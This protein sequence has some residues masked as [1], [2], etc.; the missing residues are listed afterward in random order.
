[1]T[2]PES[3][4]WPDWRRPQ[5]IALGVGAAGTLLCLLGVFLDPQQF[6]FAYLIAFLYWTGIALGGLVIWMLHNLTGGAWGALIR[7]ILEAGSRTLPLLALFFVPVALGMP[8]VYLWVNPQQAT[9]HQAELFEQKLIPGDAL[10]EFQHVL[11]EKRVL[12]EREKHLL[13]HKA[14]FLNLPFFLV[15]TAIYF[16]VWIVLAFF[17]N[18]LS[19]SQD[20]QASED[21]DRKMRGISGPGLAIYALTMTLAAID[22]IMSLEPLWWSTIFG[23]LVATGQLL[24]ALA[25][26]V[27]IAAWLSRRGP[28][29]ELASPT[30]WN[31]LGSLLLAFV[32]LWSYMMFSQLLLIYS[33]ALVEEIPW[34]TIRSAGGWQWLGLGLALFYFLLPFLVLLSRD[35]KREPRRLAVV[36]ALILFMSFV[37][38]VWMVGPV[39]SPGRFY[40]SWMTIAALAATGGFWLSFLGWQLRSRPLVPV[41]DSSVPDALHLREELRHV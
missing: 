16:V 20:R 3:Q 24:P 26:A 37:H 28:L 23:A 2:G 25:F 19:S 11:L 17:L 40:L 15:R 5:T 34:Y 10:P 38:Q 13:K 7:R 6:F 31:D 22:W 8:Y 32:M 14:P 30:A 12:P 29:A 39:F 36:A 1:M 27:L 41:H 9:A 33:G 18:R 35:F 21:V 4:A